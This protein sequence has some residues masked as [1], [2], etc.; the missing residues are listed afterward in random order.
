MFDERVGDDPK[1][2]P[3]EGP[4]DG[5]TAELVSGCEGGITIELPKGGCMSSS[6]AGFFEIC[7]NTPSTYILCEDISERCEATL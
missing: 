6:I 1:G 2:T 3:T 7:R 5:F 4:Y